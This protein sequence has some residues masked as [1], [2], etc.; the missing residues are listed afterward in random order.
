MVS[1]T[2]SHQAPERYRREMTVAQIREP[3]GPDAMEVVFLESA[4]FYRVLRSNPAF[5]DILKRLR[6]AG[7]EG[8]ALTIE[9]ASLESDIIE[10]VR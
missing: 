7:K 9:L 2:G 4:H 10:N 8:R 6:D 1:S 3:G 5:N